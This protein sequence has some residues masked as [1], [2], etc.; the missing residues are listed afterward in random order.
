[1]HF[2]QFP[3]EFL[4]SLFNR[5]ATMYRI[6]RMGLSIGCVLGAAH[7]RIRR[8]ETADQYAKEATKRYT[9]TTWRRRN[10]EHSQTLDERKVAKSDGFINTKE[11][12]QRLV[13]IKIKHLQRNSMDDCYRDWIKYLKTIRF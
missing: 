7:L 9:G 5:I 13:K 1:M 4:L 3:P 12:T 2:D 11:V 6:Q 10:K 8:N